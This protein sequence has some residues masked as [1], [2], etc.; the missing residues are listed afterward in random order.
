LQLS[1]RSDK[2]II[3]KFVTFHISPAKGQANLWSCRP[4][5]F[6]W[7]NY[8]QSG[9]FFRNTEEQCATFASQLQFCRLNF[10]TYS[11]AEIS[12]ADII[13]Q[14]RIRIKFDIRI[15]YLIAKYFLVR[16]NYRNIS[17]SKL[18]W[19][20]FFIFTPTNLNILNL[21]E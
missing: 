5:S 18:I 12:S 8:G 20:F 7:G 19:T 2:I 16:S 1:N 3:S 4:L 9:R 14:H 11:I 10:I 17:T 13:P 15:R 6:L 21:G